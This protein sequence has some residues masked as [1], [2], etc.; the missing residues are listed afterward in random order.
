MKHMQ[1]ICRAGAV[2]KVGVGEGNAYHEYEDR[3]TV[4]RLIIEN[5][6]AHFRLTEDTPPR[7]EP[8]LSDLGYLAEMAAVEA[9]LLGTNICPLGT[10]E[11]TK[12]FLKFLQRSTN[13]TTTDRIDTTFTCKD[14]CSY[15]KKANKRT[16]LLIS[17]L[18]FRH[19]KTAVE[20][21]KLSKLHAVFI[22]IAANSGYSPKQWQKGLTV[23]L[24]KKN[25]VTC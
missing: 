1:G 11:Y 14:V 25:E 3:A 18:H 16:S 13:F 22:D 10:D 21:D 5:N 19:Y 23:M 9:I 4:E 6:V 7:T 20:N 24:E 8:L 12:D 15:W 17:T 2:C